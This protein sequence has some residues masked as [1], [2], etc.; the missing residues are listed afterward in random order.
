[1]AFIK[2]KG[3]SHFRELVEEDF[4]KLGVEGQKALTWARGE[5]KEVEDDVADV[6]HKLLGDEFTK[7]KKDAQAAKAAAEENDSNT[8]ASTASKATSA[9]KPA[10][11]DPA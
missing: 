6:L 5:V 3:F 11:T 8:Q 10:S 2:Y 4:K 1:M 9:A 7:V